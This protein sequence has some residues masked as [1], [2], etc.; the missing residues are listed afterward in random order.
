M[1]VGLAYL[2]GSERAQRAKT[3]KVNQFL[4]P[5][6]YRGDKTELG[7][8]RPSCFYSM[9]QDRV[10]STANTNFFSFLFLFYCMYT[11]YIYISSFLQVMMINCFQPQNLNVCVRVHEWVPPY[12]SDLHHFHTNPP[13]SNEQ[14]YLDSLHTRG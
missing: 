3:T 12:V 9:N 13:Y 5:H 6:V 1:E 4:T 11:Y 14:R 7:W 2:P 10:K 8:T